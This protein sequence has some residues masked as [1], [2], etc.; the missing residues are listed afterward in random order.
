MTPTSDLQSQP[1]TVV[2]GSGDETQTF[3]LHESLAVK[4]SEFFTASMRNGWTEATTKTIPLSEY[5][6]EIFGAFANFIY[7]GRFELEPAR[8]GMQL[9]LKTVGQSSYKLEVLPTTTIKE[10]KNMMN[11]KEG[12]P[13]EFS[14]IVIRGDT[15]WADDDLTLSQCNINENRTAFLIRGIR[16]PRNDSGKGSYPLLDTGAARLVEH[17][18]L[19]DKLQSSSFKDYITDRLIEELHCSFYWP[20]QGSQTVYSQT[21]GNNS[22]KRLMV[23]I[24]ARMWKSDHFNN[25]TTD[26]AAY[27]FCRDLAIRMG[28]MTAEERAKPFNPEPCEFHEHKKDGTECYKAMFVQP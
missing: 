19:G 5:S 18:I 25:I 1:L 2:V 24:A 10:V 28:T 22:I 15:K 4:H 17:W 11:I 27:E 26:P 8:V 21:A 16:E 14:R 12:L 6:P 23:E 9:E 20:V 13:T 3:Y 7:H